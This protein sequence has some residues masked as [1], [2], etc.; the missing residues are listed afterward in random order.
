VSQFVSTPFGA[1]IHLA[2]R[3]FF[4]RLECW[5]PTEDIQDLLEPRAVVAGWVGLE[6]TGKFWIGLDGPNEGK[7]VLIAGERRWSTAAGSRDPNGVDPAGRASARWQANDLRCLTCGGAPE[8]LHAR[9]SVLPFRALIACLAAENLNWP[10][11]C[12]IMP[13][14]SVHTT[15]AAA[16]G[17]GRSERPA[18]ALSGGDDAVLISHGWGAVG[19]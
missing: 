17:R 14:R 11:S 1:A 6:L 8:D 10:R 18:R 12:S 5:F 19:T 3:P 9:L 7:Y 4:V 16:G 13:P 15:S 2:G